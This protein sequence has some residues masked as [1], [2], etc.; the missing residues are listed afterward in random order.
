MHLSAL[1][2]G[3]AGLRGTIGV[4]TNRMNVYTLLLRQLRVPR[5]LNAHY[6]IL[7][8]LLQGILASG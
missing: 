3:T 2:F 8:W 5:L 4:G 7:P 6:Q 1:A